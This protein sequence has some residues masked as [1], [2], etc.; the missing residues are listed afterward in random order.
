MLNETATDLLLRMTEELFGME[1]GL[2]HA[3]YEHIFFSM[4]SL[5]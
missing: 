1:D 3:R 5:L 4:L 2:A